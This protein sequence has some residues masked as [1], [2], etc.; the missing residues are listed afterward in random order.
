M[1]GGGSGVPAL[2]PA[3]EAWRR[4]LSS[5]RGS[6]RGHQAALAARQRS[7]RRWRPQGPLAHG[8]G[9]AGHEPAHKRWARVALM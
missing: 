3:H 6:A 4:G 2:G 1:A 5:R 8:I 7:D 9:A